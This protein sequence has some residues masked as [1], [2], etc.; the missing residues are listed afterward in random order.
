[1]ETSAGEDEQTPLKDFK[2]NYDIYFENYKAYICDIQDEECHKFYNHLP[3]K[4][5]SNVPTLFVMKFSPKFD[6]PLI[7]SIKVPFSPQN[8]KVFLTQIEK[9]R[10]KY[11]KFSEE[12]TENYNATNDVVRKISRNTYTSFIADNLGRDNVIMFYSSKYPWSVQLKD[13][14]IKITSKFLGILSNK[15]KISF[16]YFDML[17]NSYEPFTP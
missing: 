12:I 14:F 13:E 8:M 10:I 3:I 7:Y 1:M 9:K 2:Q 17:K 5:P 11:D 16:A 15:N 6:R 4:I